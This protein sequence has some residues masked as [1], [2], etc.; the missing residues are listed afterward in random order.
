MQPQQST[1]EYQSRSITD[2]VKK[3]VSILGKVSTR[4]AKF[5]AGIVLQSA[6]Q[7]G[8]EPWYAPPAQS[9]RWGEPQHSPHSNWFGLFFDLAYVAAAYKL[10]NL[11]KYEPSFL[12]ML[13]FLVMF[14]Q[15]FS[16]WRG[17]V[18]FNARFE[19]NDT[20]HKLMV[21]NLAIHR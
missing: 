10:G 1:A 7:T 15:L 9:H 17:S 20:F 8:W 11:L 14:L 4:A 13:W 18:M 3:R 19:S 16:V 12:G 6:N 2:R 5:T 21:S